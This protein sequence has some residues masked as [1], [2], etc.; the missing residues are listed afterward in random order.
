M[1]G[2]GSLKAALN[3]GSIKIYSGTPPVDA[4][5]AIGV[6]NTLLCTISVNS[7]GTG[8]TL[9]TP[10]SGVITKNSSEVWS[11]VNAAS[12]A[13]SFFRHVGSS[14]NGTQSASQPRIQGTVGLSGSNLNIS[15]TALTAGATQTID[16][17]TI[18]L[19]TL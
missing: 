6:G 1:L 15:N 14:D 17:Y 11:G 10:A 5:A 7:T 13:A 16:Y 19:P 12:G 3:L 4:D 8:I 18:A 2:T 9:D